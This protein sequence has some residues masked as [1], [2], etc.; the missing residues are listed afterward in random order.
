VTKDQDNASP[1]LMRA[2]LGLPPAGEGKTVVISFVK[3]DA[4]GSEAYQEYMLRHTLVSGWSQ[5]SGGDRPSESVTLNFTG[6]YYRI[7][8][9]GA[10][11]ETGSPDV[12]GYDLSAQ[13]GS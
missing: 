1:N 6:F 5:S 9:M 12:A 8:P 2:A 11:N 13:Q 4:S 10:G 3:T 7:T